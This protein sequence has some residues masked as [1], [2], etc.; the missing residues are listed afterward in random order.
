MN[1]RRRYKA[2]RR[3]ARAW[4][5]GAN[6]MASGYDQAHWLREMSTWNRRYIIVRTVNMKHRGGGYDHFLRAQDGS[7]P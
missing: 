5:A 2:K 1:K 3:R 7:R 4:M 6:P